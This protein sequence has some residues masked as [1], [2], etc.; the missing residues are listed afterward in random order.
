MPIDYMWTPA[1]KLGNILNKKTELAKQ[2]QT[3]SGSIVK[4]QQQLAECP[5]IQKSQ[6]QFFAKNF[7]VKIVKA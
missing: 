5:Q 6:S 1:Y 4:R 3:P 7:K 2:M